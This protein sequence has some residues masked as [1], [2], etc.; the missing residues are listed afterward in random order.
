MGKREQAIKSCSTAYTAMNII[1][2]HTIETRSIFAR[3]V[4]AI[5]GLLLL[6]LGYVVGYFYL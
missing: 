6:A 3:V 4:M 1:R 2:G 5:G